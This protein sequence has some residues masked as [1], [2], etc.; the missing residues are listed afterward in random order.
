MLGSLDHITRELIHISPTKRGSDF[1]AHLEELD[2]LYG[3]GRRHQRLKVPGEGSKADGSPSNITA[4][5]GAFQS[6]KYLAAAR[7]LRQLPV[8]P[9]RSANHFG[10]GT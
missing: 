5:V 6:D 7:T 10:P 9:S 8:P 4:F 3:P 2:H 1:A